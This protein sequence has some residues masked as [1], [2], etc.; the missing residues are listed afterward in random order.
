M[1]HFFFTNQWKGKKKTIIIA[2][3]LQNRTKMVAVQ[4]SVTSNENSSIYTSEAIWQISMR[5]KAT[6]EIHVLVK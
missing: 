3:A 6:C 2:T 1:K 4:N 5:K